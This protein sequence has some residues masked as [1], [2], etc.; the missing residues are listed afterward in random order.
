MKTFT[1]PAC[2]SGTVAP[3]TGRGRTSPYRNALA[4][5]I[6]D[7]FELPTCDACGESTLDSRAIKRLDAHLAKQLEALTGARVEASLEA[8]AP[9]VTRGDLERQLGLAQGYLSK[10]A[11]GAKSSSAPL[12]SLLML[13]AADPK[14]L[15]ELRRMWSP[16]APTT[17]PRKAERPA[18]AKRIRTAPAEA[19]RQSR[20]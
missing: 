12:A 14:R 19:A 15:A 2:E 4:L 10:L 8:L 7:D 13:L 11:H 16:P 18:A 6:A 20:R 3:R 9:H 1:C 17:A 5:P